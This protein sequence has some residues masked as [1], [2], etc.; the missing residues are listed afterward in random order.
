[1]SFLPVS[2]EIRALADRAMEDISTVFRKIDDTA[3]Y[4]TEKVLAAFRD[5]KVSD[6]CFAGTTGY[7]YDD[8]GRETLGR[9]YAQ[10]FGCEAGLVRIGLASGTHAITAALFAAV[11]P[12]DVLLSAT[13][14]PYDTLQGVIGIT[15]DY[16][17]S[18]KYY[19]IEYRQADLLPDLSP[20]YEAI[21][22]MAAD[23]RVA[24]VEIQRSRGYSDRGAFSVGQI[25]RICAIVHEVNPQAAVIV[26][27]CYGEF[28]ERT[29]PTD[30]GADLMAGSLIKNPGGG[31]CTGGG[32]IV[33]REDLVQAASYRMTAPGIGAEVGAT[34]DTNRLMFQGFFL[35]PHTTAQALKTAVFA[36]RLMELM[37]FSSFPAWNAER[38][39][40]VQAV[41]LNSPEML[42]RFC[43]GIQAGA[44]VDSFVTPVAAP[45]PGYE[46][47]VIMAA[48]A[49]VQGASIELSADGPMRPPY[50]AY[51]QGGIT[52]ESAKLGILLAAERMNQYEKES[53][54]S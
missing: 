37:G 11:K 50:R 38:S 9:I 8:L 17:G 34:Y 24:A 29:E 15:G 5:Q 53:V 43:E 30:V 3:Q 12:G 48:G 46:D 35:A 49:F 41:D 10:V 19:G 54:R 28:T 25:G 40:I 32:Y 22:R 13:G 1:M 31:I 36:A 26:D 44:P 52:F 21:R 23:P 39:D 20:D 14:L 45:M 42:T 4:N 16:P 47:P 6:A 2:D 33:G 18:L 51:L 7:G 27:N